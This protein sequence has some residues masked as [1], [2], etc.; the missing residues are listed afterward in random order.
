MD[1]KQVKK[2]LEKP[3]CLD[4]LDDMTCYQR[5]QDDCDGDYGQRLNVIMGVDGDMHVSILGDNPCLRFRN[6][7]GGGMSLRTHNALKILAE[8]IRLDNEERPQFDR[9]LLP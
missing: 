2:M 9:Q 3:L 5:V 1:K 6:F 4:L 7:F 8:A